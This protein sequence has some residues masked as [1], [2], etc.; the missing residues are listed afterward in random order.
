[1]KNE[2][3]R[4]KREAREEIEEQRRDYETRLKRQLKKLATAEKENTCDN[5]GEKYRNE[6]LC[7]EVDRLNLKIQGL[8]HEKK[9]VEAEVG[10]LQ[11]LT[12]G[13]QQKNKN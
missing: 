3:E 11:Q 10:R 12:E 2:V 4:V 8:E 6:Q 13:L 9:T 5:Q 1:M 7:R